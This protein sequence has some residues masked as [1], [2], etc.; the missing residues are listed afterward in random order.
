MKLALVA[1]AIFA[2]AA[3]AGCNNGPK[4]VEDKPMV[5]HM[6]LNVHK[7]SCTF[8]PTGKAGALKPAGTLTLTDVEG[9][10]KIEGAI[11]GLKPDSK[12]GFH[13]H[14]LGDVSSSSDGLSVGTHYDPKGP[15]DHGGPDSANRHHGDL[16]NVSTDKDGVAKVSIV[17]KDVS[18]SGANNPILGRSLVIH[19]NPDNLTNTPS[20]GGSGDRIAFGVIGIAKA[21]VKPTLGTAPAK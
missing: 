8:A 15:H 20:G 5:H 10:V 21:D 4:W 18:I 16:G 14:E 13:I 11:T 3:I 9:G 17:V 6:G 7:A 19:A 12:H 1:T 2:A